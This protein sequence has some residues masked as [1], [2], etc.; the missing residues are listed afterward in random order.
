MIKT[1]EYN[2]LDNDDKGTLLYENNDEQVLCFERASLIFIFNFN[3]S[4]SFDHLPIRTDPGKYRLLLDSDSKS[5]A[6]HNR[7]APKQ[8]YFTQTDKNE[9]HHYITVYLPTRTVL[10]L[11]SDFLIKI[12]PYASGSKLM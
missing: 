11:T 3:P 5:F 8:V 12:E 6:G 1:A 7:L 4:R 2:L 10:V 9:S